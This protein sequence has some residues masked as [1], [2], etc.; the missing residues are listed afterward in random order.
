MHADTLNG[1]Y[2]AHM[3]VIEVRNGTGKKT[4]VDILPSGKKR[5]TVKN[6]SGKEVEAIRRRRF[7]PDLFKG[8][9]YGLRNGPGAAPLSGNARKTLKNKKGRKQ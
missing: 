3:N 9:L 8:M 1:K 4:V 2:Q 7:I 5:K 6:L